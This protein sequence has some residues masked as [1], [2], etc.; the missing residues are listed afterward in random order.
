MD[1]R[2]AVAEIGALI[3]ASDARNEKSNAETNARIDALQAGR[4]I[5]S[6][7]EINAQ[8]KAIISDIKTVKKLLWRIIIIAP[9]ILVLINAGILYDMFRN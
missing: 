9:A 8:T 5:Q 6:I 2:D 1:D 7:A 3:A 4:N